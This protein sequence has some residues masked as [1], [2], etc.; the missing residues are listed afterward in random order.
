MTR[1]Y[2]RG[3]PLERVL[4]RVEIAPS[5]C[6]LMPTSS[7]TGYA[8]VRAIKDG[9]GKSWYA[10]R[11]TYEAMVAPIPDG[12]TIDHLCRVRNCC[13]PDHLE[14]VPPAENTRR[15]VKVRYNGP[16]PVVRKGHCPAGHPYDATNGRV[17]RNGSVVC[18]TCHND[19]ARATRRNLRETIGPK[20]VV[21][22]PAPLL[23]VIDERARRSRLPRNEL[24]RKALSAAFPIDI[25]NHLGEQQ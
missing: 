24:I 6:W 20:V 23:D 14:A 22:I 25:D 12:Y 16:K 11:L 17:R 9:V 15:A 8:A 1:Q 2:V 19:S 13:N 18:R 7:K 3:T 5:G 4:A 10:H 21:N